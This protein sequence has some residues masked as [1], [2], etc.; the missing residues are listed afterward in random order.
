MTVSRHPA[1]APSLGGIEVQGVTRSAFLLR[2]ALAAGAAG[3]A[4]AVGPFV[5]RALAQGKNGD[6]EILNFALTLEY[7]EAVFYDRGSDIGLSGDVKTLARAFGD[8]EAK[9][10]ETLK[11]TITSLGGTPVT[12][13]TF[14]FPIA[15]QSSFVALAVTLEDTGVS[16]YNGAAPGIKSKEVL[17]A[18]G[19]IVQIEARHAAALRMV[20]M[21]KPAP[22][23][24]DEAFARQKVLDA[25]APFIKS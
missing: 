13:P 25:A 6:V 11:T 15:D 10:V 14:E 21:E 7:L 19:T 8:D 17:A 16:A 1:A 12:K 20:A 23:A 4:G 5:S 24:F 3:G 18:A 9:H 2:A 22:D